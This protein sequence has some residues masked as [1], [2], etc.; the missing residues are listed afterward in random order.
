M[1]NVKGKKKILKGAREKQLV[2][3]KATFI[4]LSRDFSAA[5]SQA[6]RKWHNVFKLLKGK[7]KQTNKQNKKKKLTN[8]TLPG[9]TAKIGEVAETGPISCTIGR[10][11]NW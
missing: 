7:N 4:R 3:Y 9:K 2:A 6:R 1:S 5:T 10:N 11:I 8:N